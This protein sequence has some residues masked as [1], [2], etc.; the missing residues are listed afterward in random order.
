MPLPD[1]SPREIRLG[2]F[3]AFC[4]ALYAVVGILF[5]AFPQ[6]TFRVAGMGA[7][8]ELTAEVRFWQVL[9]VGM[10]A[11][12]SVACALVAHSPRERRV[13]LAGASTG[14]SIALIA[15]ARPELTRHVSLV[16]AVAPFADIERIA[17]LATTRSYEEDDGAMVE[18]AV[19]ALLR[20]AVAR[21]LVAC[22]RDARD[23]D[24]LLDRI[25]TIEEESD[26]L[27]ALEVELDG[28]GPET[29][30]V[31]RLLTNRDP[32]RFR[33]F[34][35][36]L[37]PDMLSTLRELSPLAQATSLAV[38]VELAVPPQDPYF[39]FREASTL[40][41]SLPNVRLTVTSTLDHTRPTA[42]LRGLRDLARFDGFVVRTLAGAA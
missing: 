20:R 2:R 29:Q 16:A 28:L 8:A 39:P 36:A 3:A 32:A 30:T 15:A 1:L 37:P 35:G 38:P 12:I 31:V 9:A 26:A 40:A 17:C 19:T 34:Y 4:S 23:R 7:S 24:L 25:G 41:E 42:S 22:L 18:Y 11:A 13:A 6:W 27:E 33:D 14:A 5:A 21:S 10:M